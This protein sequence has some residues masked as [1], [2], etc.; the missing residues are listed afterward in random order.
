MSRPTPSGLF[1]RFA[2]ALS[3]WSGRPVTFALSLALIVFWAI[4]GPLFGF[5]SIWQFIINTLTSIVTLLLVFLLQSSQ[6]RDGKALQAKIDELILSSKARNKFVGI[7]RLD[8]DRFQEICATLPEPDKEECESG[9]IVLDPRV[10]NC[11]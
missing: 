7:E 5:S 8:E 6:N 4:S 11:Q 1:A 10:T 9:V 2:S 3:E